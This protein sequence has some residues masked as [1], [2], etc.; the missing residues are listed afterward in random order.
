MGRGQPVDDITNL[1]HIKPET[2]GLLFNEGSC[3]RGTYK[4]HVAV[5]YH[6]V[7]SADIFRILPS[8]FNDRL[9]IRLKISGTFEVSGNFIDNHIGSDYFTNQPAPGTCCSA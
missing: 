8:D 7:P 5:H 6:S 4:V 9:D 3:A 2:V 1:P